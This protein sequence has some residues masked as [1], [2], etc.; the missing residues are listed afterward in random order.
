MDGTA[1]REVVCVI[2]T[3]ESESL[4]SDIMAVEG[5]GGWM[6]FDVNGLLR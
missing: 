1:V 6:E 3:S 2:S 5:G 4:R